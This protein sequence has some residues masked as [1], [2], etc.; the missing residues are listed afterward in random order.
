MNG[1][2]TIPKVLI[3]LRKY[4]LND[5]P[6]IDVCIALNNFR[7]TKIANTRFSSVLLLKSTFPMIY[8]WPEKCSRSKFFPFHVVNWLTMGFYAKNL[9]KTWVCKVF[10][11][12]NREICNVRVAMDFVFVFVFFP[13]HQVLKSLACEMDETNTIWNGWMSWPSNDWCILYTDLDIK[14]IGNCIVRSVCR[15][16]RIWYE[17]GLIMYEK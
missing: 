14:C 3:N 9:C 5:D 7:A 8:C 4:R 12:S 10:Q 6:N 2:K 17:C 13:L 16:I 15:S 1:K 11:W